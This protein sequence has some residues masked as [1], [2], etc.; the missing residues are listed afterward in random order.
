MGRSVERLL[1]FAVEPAV[2]VELLLLRHVGRPLLEL[3]LELGAVVELGPVMELGACLEL[4]TLLG[5]G[6]GMGAC[7]GAGL[8]SAARLERARG[9]RPRPIYWGDGRPAGRPTYRPGNG[10]NGA[11]GRPTYSGGYRRND[12]GTGVTINQSGG[13]RR[14][15]TTGTP[16]ATIRPGGSNNQYTPQGT[17]RPGV[18]GND[19]Y[20]RPV[21]TDRSYRREVRPNTT[22]AERPQRSVQ[23]SEPTR[24][25]AVSPSRPAG[26]SY[27]GS[28]AGGGG[29]YRRR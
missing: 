23:R 26:G 16:A 9:G 4:G 6:P 17:T 22:P 19:G 24:T 25:P 27:G 29:G 10:P 28:G 13:T 1:V 18:N 20:R 8:L 15:A 11:G 2:A 3:E 14:P 5:M 12:N 21:N 7:L